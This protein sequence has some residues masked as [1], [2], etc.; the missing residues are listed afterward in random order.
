M[1]PP[2]W[3][4]S[5]CFHI[6][7]Q[8]S[9]ARPPCWCRSTPLSGIGQPLHSQSAEAAGCRFLGALGPASRRPPPFPGGSMPECRRQAVFFSPTPGPGLRSGRGLAI[10]FPQLV[11][12]V[13]TWSASPVFSCANALRSQGERPLTVIAS[14]AKQSSFPLAQLKPG[15]AFVPA[16]AS[17]AMTRFFLSISTVLPPH[18]TR[19]AIFPSSYL[20]R[21]H[22][23]AGPKCQIQARKA[24]RAPARTSAS[25]KD[26]K[27]E[28][29]VPVPPCSRDPPWYLSPAPEVFELTSCV[30]PWPPG[31]EIPTFP[32]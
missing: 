18:S 2:P 28:K 17:C 8:Y 24:A 27:M 30:F 15:I 1:I 29:K 5:R 25:A 20:D 7:P 3:A 11:A 16:G 32:P 19:P 4:G 10:F 21:S 14:G 13:S 12:V 6:M 22:R 26:R 9:H 31:S 23:P